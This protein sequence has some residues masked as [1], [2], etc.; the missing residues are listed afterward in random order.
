MSTGTGAG[1]G[2][3]AAAGG[4]APRSSTARVALGWALVGVPLAYGVVETVLRAS[5]LFTG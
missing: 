5:K 3:G 1:T 2:A 4:G